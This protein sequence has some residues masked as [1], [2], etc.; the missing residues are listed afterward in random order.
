M[1]NTDQSGAK[2]EVVPSRRMPQSK[3]LA[4]WVIL[5]LRLLALGGTV[6]ATLVMALNKQSKTLIVGTIGTTP[7]TAT[8]E[9]KFQHTP[10]F[11]FFVIA[12][13]VGSLHNLLMLAMDLFG[14]KFDFKGF[15]LLTIT[16]LDM[17]TIA[18]LSTG[19]GAAASISE[20]GK[21]GNSH[22]RW[23]KVCDRFGTYCD[24]GMGALIAAFLGIIFLMVINAISI[25][26][27][28]KKTTS[29]STVVSG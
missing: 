5:F 16:L 15:R 3:K 28:H 26:N 10:A 12:N 27:L 19:A 14:Y 11:V 22:A 18:L 6:S 1:E 20:V 13:S 8:I 25:I 7:I 24:H 29:Q 23:N 17:A 2:P 4:N 9:A 21:N